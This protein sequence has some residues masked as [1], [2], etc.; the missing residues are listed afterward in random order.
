MLGSKKDADSQASSIRLPCSRRESR[1]FTRR[2][3]I[4]NVAQATFFENG[5][6]GTS[7]SEIAGTIGGSKGTLW[8]YFSSKEMLFAAVVERASQ[9][10]RQQL[11]VILDPDIEIGETL[12]RFA[13]EYLQKVTSP[14]AVALNRLVIGETNRFPETG[15]IF[16]ERAVGRTRQMLADYLEEAMTR[17]LLCRGDS[18][19]AAQH[20]IGLVSSGC[21][22]QLLVGLISTVDDAVLD[23]DAELGVAAFLRAHQL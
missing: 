17:G 11:S 4:L 21:S 7:M 10:F 15:R 20:L 19:V 22:H 16:Y 1:R 13:R 5:Y 18:I 23:Q 2:E 8:S 3:A 12:R 9:S 14:Q 6:A